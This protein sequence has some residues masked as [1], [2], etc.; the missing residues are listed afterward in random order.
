MKHEA[1][2][3]RPLADVDLERVALVAREIWYQHY[4]GI[5]T[6]RQIEFMLKQRYRPEVIRAQLVAGQSWWYG[7]WAGDDL[8]G[9]AACEPGNH[10]FAMKL[11]K[12]Y[13][14]LRYRGQGHGRALMEQAERLARER[15]CA[16][17]YLQVN[18]YNARSIQFYLRSGFA[19]SD[20]VRVEIGNGFVM[21]DYIMDR[22]LERSGASGATNSAAG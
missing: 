20:A 19:V 21:D 14:R 5:I 9:F 1:A 13:V 16:R 17:I 3:I 6:V 11:D 22:P 12:L 8:S 10:P 4:P 15:G 7:A 18:K 2:Q